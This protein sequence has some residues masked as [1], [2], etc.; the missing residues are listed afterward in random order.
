MNKPT[1]VGSVVVIALGTFL[2]GRYTGKPTSQDLPKAKHILYYVDPMHPA[3][4]SDK[5]GTAPD[6]GMA[7][8]PVYEGEDLASKLQLAPGAVAISHD[9]QQLIGVRVEPVEKNSGSR[10]V[11]TTGRVAANDNLVYKL[12]AGTDGWIQSLQDNP[13]GTLVKQNQLLATF[14]SR[15]FR[16]AEQAYIGS[17]AS[18]D[19]VK[20]VR[21]DDQGRVSDSSVRI[22]EEQLRTLGMSEQQVHEL[23]ASRQVTGDIQIL[24]P[25]DGVVLAQ[26]ISPAQ[27][28]EKGTELYRVADLSKVWILADLFG[29]Q[30][31]ALK[32]NM[33]VTVN[34]RE[35]ARTI[36]AKVSDVPPLFD[37]A[38]RT[39]KLRLEADNPGMLLRPEMLVD[40]VFQVP[41]P[42]GISVPQEAVLDSG[43]QKI[44]YLE[45]KDGVFEP[46]SVEL[47]AA[48][49]GRVSVKRGLAEGDR[50]VTS[51]NFLI[52]SESR[53]RPSAA[54]PMNEKHDSPAAH[55]QPKLQNASMA[56][57]NMVHDPVCGMSIDHNEAVANGHTEIYN[58]QTLAF[59]SDRCR[60]KFKV[61]PSKYL[62]DKI[63][64]AA[65]TGAGRQDD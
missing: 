36:S 38:S 31:G 13:A 16:N 45:T 34:V 33:R 43:L 21:P 30:A 56:S 17:L 53:M 64:T 19:R 27:R 52:D 35:L 42:V 12:T 54:Q 4:K 61:N 32:P 41:A 25:V 50:V 48:F 65:N 49:A 22:N 57:A 7:L 9:K 18:I 26:D 14:Y 29:D 1:A 3:Y 40:V 23:G 51:G 11:R 58:G 46:R 60:D 5:P 15:E 2:A 8:E 37:S 24:S 55:V 63:K 44:V 39:L 6:C 62:E 20:A 28:F 47:G 10:Q 59:C